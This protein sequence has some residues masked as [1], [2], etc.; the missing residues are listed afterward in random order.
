MSTIRKIALRAN[1]VCMAELVVQK[2]DD[3]IFK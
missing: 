2:V 1:H 3:M